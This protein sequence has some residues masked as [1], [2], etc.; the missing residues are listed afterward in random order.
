[1]PEDACVS[2][3]KQN[4][5][6]T[7]RITH[8]NQNTLD[9]SRL[10]IVVNPNAHLTRLTVSRFNHLNEQLHAPNPPPPPLAS[11]RKPFMT[12]PTKLKPVALNFATMDNVNDGEAWFPPIGDWVSQVS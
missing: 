5:N 12:P 10:L 2:S 11:L 1:M 7:S 9:C 8:N 6:K 3:S 4:T